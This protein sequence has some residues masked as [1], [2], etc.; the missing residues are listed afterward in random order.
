MTEAEQ[1]LKEPGRGFTENSS[2]MGNLPALVRVRAILLAFT[3]E[4]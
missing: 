4:S 3:D 1:R 2:E